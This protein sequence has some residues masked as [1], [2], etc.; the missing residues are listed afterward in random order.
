[1]S[2]RTQGPRADGEL[3]KFPLRARTFMSAET[4]IL[5]ACMSCGAVNRVA[6]SKAQ[7]G[8]VCG[9]CQQQLPVHGLVCDVT[10]QG[11]WKIIKNAK[12]PVAVDF[13]A[14]WCPPC[15]VYGPIFEELSV[16]M[17]GAAQFLKVNTERVPS[18]SQRFQITGIPTT[19]V[20]VGGEKRMQQAGAI[21]KAQLKSML[22]SLL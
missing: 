18:L 20:F 1:M 10:E 9:K 3:L 5:A 11:F 13:W 17:A 21:P 12:V 16:D 2:E 14:E 6:V 19:M 15:R 8:P 7:S 4:T 22:Q